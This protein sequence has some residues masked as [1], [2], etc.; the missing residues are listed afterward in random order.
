M[1]QIRFSQ[2]FIVC[3]ILISTG[4]S[5]EKPVPSLPAISLNAASV[6]SLTR[7][8]E[9]AVSPEMPE[10][11][12]LSLWAV[13]TLAPDP[14][15]LHLEENGIA[16]IT[17][18]TRRRSSEIDIRAH[19]NW[20]IS[21]ISF[22]TV[23]DR[24]NFIHSALSPENSNDNLWL[25]DKNGDGSHDWKDLTLDKE[26]VFRIEDRDG[27]GKADY[28]ALVIEDFHEE[29]SDVAGAMVVYD[30]YIFVGVGP[31]L[32]RLKDEN[33]D[34]IIEEKKLLL[35]G[36][37]VHM[38][39]GGHNMSGL[40]VGPDGK[41]WWGIGDIGS[42]VTDQQGKVWDY[43]NQGA[44]FRCNTDGSDF[45][46]FAA[47]LRNTHEFTFD[48]YGNL[49]TV[50]NDGDHPG[51]S[52]R[53]V[54]LINGSDSGWRINWQFGKYSDPD[55]NTYKVWMDEKLYVPRWEGQAAHI[56]PPIRNYHNGPTG[57]KFNP[58]T[59]LSEK[60]KN[61]FF[62][63]EFTGTPARS[64]VWA[65]SLKPKGAGFE[66][67]GEEKVLGSILATGLDFGPDGALYVADWMDGWATKQHG[68]IWKLDVKGAENS[69]VRKEVQSLLAENFTLRTPES[70]AGFLGHPDKRI[71]QKAQFALVKMGEAGINILKST[72]SPTRPQLARVHAIWG[73]TQ[74]ARA[75]PSFAA[76]LQ[77]LLRDN[78]PEIR[79]QA[80][81][82]LGEAGFTAAAEDLIPLLEDS[83]ARVRMFATE[84]LGRMAYVQAIHP[85]VAMLEKNNDEDIYLRHAGAIAL[86]RIDRRGPISELSAHPSKAVRIAAL[87]ALRRMR[88]QE[89]KL[90]LHDSDEWVA[91]EAAKAINDD[92]GIEAAMPDLA[93]YLD[94]PAFNN[95][96]L[97]RRAINANLRTGKKENLERIA[98]YAERNA[99]AEILRAEAI[100]TIGTWPHPSV[101]DRVDGFYHG[102]VSR[103]TTE[104][105]EI[106]SNILPAIWKTR[107]A[108]IKIAAIDA[109]ARLQL[110]AASPDIYTLLQKDQNENVRAAALDGLFRLHFPDIET[111]VL[112]A[113][114]DKKS[115]VR[116]I[117]LSLVS[118]LRSTDE[119]KAEL[120][121]LAIENGSPGEQQ[122]ALEALG[123][124]PADASLPLVTSLLDRLDAGTLP[125]EI[126]LELLE[127]IE[128]TGSEE[129]KNRLAEW[130]KERENKDVP[131][132]WSEA[133]KGGD[134][135]KG[136]Q[137]FLNNES[138]MCTRC[139]A[140]GD[141]GA[142]VGPN[143]DNVGTRLSREDILES[144]ID[145]GA[146][147]AAGFGIV[148]LK[149]KDGTEKNGILMEES[150]AHITIKAADNALI[151]IPKS[152]VAERQNAP[153]SMPAM[154]NIL[155][156]REIRD[157]VE[158]LSSLRPTPP[159]P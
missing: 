73:I 75:E 46:V 85:I 20:M 84:A 22:Q 152:S 120:L 36:F 95:E 3:C 106:L 76:S 55:N 68:R 17:S 121:G 37:G 154:G 139:H 65:F 61:Q 44:I 12:T 53:L 105:R 92:N 116:I 117:G 99:E 155:S 132:S 8:T 87:V 34:G 145:P 51:E 29:F 1:N 56:L 133:L 72:L 82:W 41:I 130:Q 70:L 24:K 81:R 59:A 50:D 122:S 129:I 111:A 148:M 48:E 47:G 159:L 7:L 11:L 141:G 42:Y 77:P 104:A 112:I 54:Y 123:G 33:S 125:G 128:K 134:A 140:I 40:T 5:C 108:G 150:S 131:E 57:M 66:F 91:T 151:R 74:A 45:E 90:F 38:G 102:P 93:A 109:A 86:A 110:T 64:N 19:R 88:A 97:I 138:A 25:N 6:D 119:K 14:I 144:L 43:A 153:S 32:W 31:E 63:A 60:Y 62:F 83:S 26:R 39:F 115:E 127:V 10:G 107:S 157:V 136:R 78:D 13:D 58:G 35:S 79:A 96:A 94:Q 146:K 98:R 4:F 30:G 52:E 9:A 143:L 156:R 71:R 80:A 18:T 142:T 158:F 89:V 15:A 21:S 69:P 149:M 23:E 114:N 28:A 124:L 49:I 135:R 16:Y 147:L 126:Q 118:Q 101:V 27:D 100:A 113:L 137:L 2:Y 67:E 103:D